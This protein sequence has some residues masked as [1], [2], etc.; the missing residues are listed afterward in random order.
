MWRNCA[1]WS[2]NWKRGSAAVTDDLLRMLCGA[3]LG[4]M[5]VLLL[6]RPARRVFGADAAFTLW[7]FPLV[8]A[9]APVLPQKI[10]PRAMIAVPG[11]TVTPH[12]AASIAAQ[13][14]AIDWTQWLLAI[15]LIGVAG[16]LLRLVVHYVR[17]L[18]G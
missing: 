10:A 18:R 5:L 2:I 15:W 11:L 1:S 17:L 4:L 7:L 12:L 8:L 14:A 9:L 13:P 6:R 3:T 16:A